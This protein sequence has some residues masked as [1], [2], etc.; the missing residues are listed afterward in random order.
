MR[1]L[2][3]CFLLLS[4]LVS[5]NLKDEGKEKVKTY[6]DLESFF[7]SEA[8]RLSAKNQMIDKTVIINGKAE[9]K[10]LTIT[11]W[12]KEFS[13][14]IDA[15]INKASWKGSFASSNVNHTTIYTSNSAKIAVKKLEV[16]SENGKILA[17]KIFVANINSLYTAKDS[18]SYYPDSLYEIKKVQHIK[19]MEEKKYEVIG[20]FKP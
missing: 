7:K 17:I 10:K 3:C 6:F 2:F 11:N 15:D 18:L 9:H 12:E 16:T 19:L 8:K 1:L 14:F 4:S 5:C 13:A 20:K